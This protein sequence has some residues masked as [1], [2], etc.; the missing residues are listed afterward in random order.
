LARDLHARSGDHDASALARQLALHSAALVEWLV[1]V[2]GVDLTLVEARPPG[3]A[4]ARLHAPPARR[5]QDL[6]DD[7]ARAVARRGIALHCGRPVAGLIG[8]DTAILGAVAETAP[9][10][11]ARIGARKIVLA[12]GGFVREP[13]LLRRFC[14]GAA[15]ARADD[16]SGGTGD[17]LL[18]GLGLGAAVANLGAFEADLAT[19]AV[20]RTQGGLQVDADGRVLR[21]DGEPIAN[22]FAAGG[23]AAGIAGARSAVGYLAGSALLAALGLGRLAGRAAAAE[24]REDR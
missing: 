12:S 4:V 22:L 23:A 13:A 17:A 2:G 3:H 9:A 20:T 24:V 5:G 16:R 6:L 15:P 10:A 14:P 11:I 19:G 18:W 21:R 7:L 1:D 8:D